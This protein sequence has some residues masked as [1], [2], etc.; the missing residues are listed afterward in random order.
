MGYA[1]TVACRRGPAL[2]VLVLASVSPQ[3]L[4]TTP[5]SAKAPDWPP[6]LTAASSALEQGE[7]VHMIRRFPSPETTRSDRL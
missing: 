5:A 2:F 3:R 7:M 1:L 6:E 4:V